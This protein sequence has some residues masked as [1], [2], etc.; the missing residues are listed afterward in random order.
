MTADDPQE[1]PP[2]LEEDLS[3]SSEGE[4]ASAIASVL[5]DQAEK[6]EVRSFVRSPGPK[7]LLPQLAGL[8][9]ASLVA[10]YVWFATPGWLE[11]APIPPPPVEVELATLRL[12]MFIQAQAIE[13][14]RLN[15]GRTPAFLE[16]AG[17]PRPG[18]RYRRVDADTYILQ[19]QGDRVRLVYT[20]RDSLGAFLGE[21][22]EALLVGAQ[23]P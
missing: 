6:A 1:H 15:N 23:A 13:S 5:K 22:G 12:E 16:E 7:P 20:S 8:G 9:I 14:Y 21:E 10:A 18:V 3:L 4:R 2:R 11:P 19:G 17:P